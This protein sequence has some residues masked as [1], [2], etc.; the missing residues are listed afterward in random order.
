MR[1]VIDELKAAARRLHRQAQSGNPS[2]LDRL[3]KLPEW[4]RARDEEIVQGVRRR[5]C[6]SLL[7]QDAGFAGW[8]HLVGVL[9]GTEQSDFGTLLYP[10]RCCAHWN[11]WLA[12]YEEARQ[13]RGE[14]GGYLL[15]YG[16]Q[17]L[18]VDEHFLRT[19]GLDPEGED[20]RLVG[21]DWVH[22]KSVEARSRIYGRLIRAAL[23]A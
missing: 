16:K 10:P 14:H 23:A 15:A 20:L 19:L 12:S 4:S 11:I 21:R 2:A 8:A 9:K 17:Y 1:N 6:L 18:I 7:A 5:H 22:P 13:I 3:R